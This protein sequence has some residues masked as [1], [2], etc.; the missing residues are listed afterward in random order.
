MIY[1]AIEGT[2]MNINQI[3]NDLTYWFDYG[4]HMVLHHP[5]TSLT[6]VVGAFL[7]HQALGAMKLITSVIAFVLAA[8][9][10]LFLDWLVF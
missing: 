7:F 8:L 10:A 3:I 6:A 1:T 5:F 2:N 9:T 4:M